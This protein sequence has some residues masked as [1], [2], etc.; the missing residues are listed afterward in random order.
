VKVISIAFVYTQAFAATYAVVLASMDTLFNC[1][2]VIR[3]GPCCHLV[4][5]SSAPR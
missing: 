1:I 3:R 5:P 2:G 4:L